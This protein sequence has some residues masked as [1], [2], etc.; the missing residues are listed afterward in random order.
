MRRNKGFTLIELMIVIAIIAIIAAIAI[1]GLLQSQRASNER[2]A[3]ASLKT[4]A[5]AE[6][7]FR[8]NDRDGNR[9]T[10]F[11]TDDVSGLY[12]LENEADAGAGGPVGFQPIKLIELSIAGADALP[13]LRPRGDVVTAFTIQSAKAG[14]W[15]F[16]MVMDNSEPAGPAPYQTSTNG[17]TPWTAGLTHNTSKFAFSAYPDSLSAGKSAYIM[18]EENTIYR[19]ALNVDPTPGP[20]VPPGAPGGGQAALMTDWP[21]DGVRLASYSKLD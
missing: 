4:L 5:T 18:N 6:A 1:P 2:N 15:Y 17:I 10:D 3:S 12:C 20:A 16:A 21:A 11:W 9:V 19:L 7:D 13:G 14:Y 8:A